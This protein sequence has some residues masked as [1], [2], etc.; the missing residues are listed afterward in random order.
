V[1]GLIPLIM[2]TG[3]A[4]GIGI[5]IRTASRRRAMWREGA[6]RLGMTDIDERGLVYPDIRGRIDGMLVRVQEF[7][8]GNAVRTRVSIH[9]PGLLPQRLELR[10]ENLGTAIEKIV[11]GPDVEVGD[12][13]FDRTVL[14]RGHPVLAVALL[15]ADVRRQVTSAVQAGARI[16]N[17]RLT[18]E[19]DKI[20]NRAHFTTEVG[21]LV[22][23]V[24]ALRQP[25]SPASLLALNA[26][27]DPEHGVRL[28][29]LELLIERFPEHQE[30]TQ[31]L[32][33]LLDDPLPEI[34]LKAAAGV[35]EE[36]V[37]V[38]AALATNVETSEAVAAEALRAVGASLA[39]ERTLD[40]LN[41]ALRNRRRSVALAA[42]EVLGERPDEAAAAR[43]RTVLDAADSELAAAAARALGEIRDPRAE[44]P[45]LTALEH[46][47]A[48]LRVAA[49]EALGAVG[50][51]MAVGPL[52]AASAAHPLDLNLRRVVAT[53]VADIQSRATGA[54]PGQLSL[55]DAGEGELA[56]SEDEAGQVSLV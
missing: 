50:S 38:L 56:L 21:G 12:D 48:A 19:R 18:A 43:L 47:D 46:A 26:R 37:P 16:R 34:R 51:V 11:Q 15:D 29:N 6:H 2:L 14:V 39:V 5:H 30:T 7:K 22:K 41:H 10:A 36:G 20:Y 33:D 27:S 54:A 4:I 40:V 1:E 42:I 8:S 31:V 23:L 52:R 55:T 32:P 44:E 49:A 3:F 24:R 53:A 45:L 13:H 25:A 28:R 35:G 9:A 17:G